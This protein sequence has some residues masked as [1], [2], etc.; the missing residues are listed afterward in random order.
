M[1]SLREIGNT[2]FIRQSCRATFGV[3]WALEALNLDLN[4]SVS[5]QPTYS[6]RRLMYEIFLMMFSI[7]RRVESVSIG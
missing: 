3:E 6:S 2:H 7:I 1:A 4:F 5:I